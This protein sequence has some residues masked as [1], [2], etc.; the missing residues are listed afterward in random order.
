MSLLST[1]MKDYPYSAS[2]REPL[3][4]SSAAGGPYVSPTSNRL[5]HIL[6]SNRYSSECEKK[7]YP[8]RHSTS[9]SN[10]EEINQDEFKSEE[11]AEEEDVEGE[12][13]SKDRSTLGFVNVETL[14]FV[15]YREE[16]RKA[17]RA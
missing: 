9:F 12:E 1:E 5:Q 7:S 16:K 3:I 11:Y 13:L 4:S 15:N 17:L 10:L 8:I 14:H 6:E 2:M